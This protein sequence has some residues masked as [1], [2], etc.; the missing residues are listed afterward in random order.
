MDKKVLIL[1][2]KGNL[3]H[4]L[5]GVFAPDY[6]VLA[7]DR[8]DIDITDNELIRKKI[9]DLKPFLVI[10]ATGYNAV[11]KCENDEAEYDLAKKL[12]GEAVGN[13][14]QG[15]LENGAIFINYSSDYVFSGDKKEGYLEDDE[16]NPINN[17]GRSKQ[18]GEK[19]I[20]RLSGSGLK[21]Y[22]IRPQKLF[23]P[24]G[25]SDLAKPSFFDTMLKLAKERN[26][27]DAVNEEE[28]NFTYT[29]DLAKATRD[30]IE[31]NKGY[32]IYHIS[33]PFPATWYKAA[34][35]LFKIAGVD[36]K[37]NPVSS[38]K[39]PRPAKRPKYSTLL[40]TKMPPLR[41]WREALREYLGK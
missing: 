30:L 18:M 29:P 9:S 17:Y 23:G 10:N 28:S 16:T 14:A 20:L 5:I 1:G 7:W 37:V 35:E 13:I 39:F 31:M 26:E 33:N 32:G 2:G 12:N 38:E 24:Q 40:N 8:S 15:C 41:D 4:Q 6:E 21:W 22:I 3:G 19:E 36:I 11:D 25:P 34:R 27:L